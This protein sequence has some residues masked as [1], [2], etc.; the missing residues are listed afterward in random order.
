M[1]RLFYFSEPQFPHLPDGDDRSTTSQALLWGL[2]RQCGIMCLIQCLAWIKCLIKGGGG[3][4][5]SGDQDVF[6][7]LF[8]VSVDMTLMG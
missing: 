5:D 4:D 3:D 1:G 6:F 7:S 8:K 2:M